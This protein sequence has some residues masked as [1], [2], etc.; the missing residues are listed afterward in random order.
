MF[1]CVLFHILPLKL[2]WPQ[3]SKSGVLIW[4]WK[5]KPLCDVV[6]AAPASFLPDV[7]VVF[8]ILHPSAGSLC[9]GCVC[10]VGSQTNFFLCVLQR[11]HLQ[12]TSVRME[13]P[14]IIRWTT[15]WTQVM[16]CFLWLICWISVR[17]C[18]MFVCFW[19]HCFFTYFY[20]DWNGSWIFV[21]A[22]CNDLK[23]NQN[24]FCP[25]YLVNMLFCFSGSPNLSPNPVSPAHNNLG[26]TS[27]LVC[28]CYMG[29]FG[30][31]KML[32]FNFMVYNTKCFL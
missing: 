30:Q 17:T 13:K 23:C 18:S 26:N 1:V 28:V 12:A 8:L 3:L 25:G 20:F 27:L 31:I 29:H 15:A 16:D 24:F 7:F 22:L 6:S 4:G 21:C 9:N 32:G 10:F 14:A 19:L 5:I 2:S 11:R